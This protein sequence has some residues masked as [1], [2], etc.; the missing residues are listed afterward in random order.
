MQPRDADEPL[1]AEHMQQLAEANDRLGKLKPACV[2]AGFNGWTC[3][4]FAVLCVPFA[5]FSITAG[6]LTVGLGAVAWN[7]FRGR[8]L[9]KQFDLCGPRLL[10]WNQ[11]GFLALLIGY[12]SWQIFRSLTGPSPYESYVQ[13]NAELESMLGPIGE[14]HVI[15]SLAIYGGLIVGSIIFQG[16]NALYYFTRARHI[17]THLAQTA[18]WIVRV[19][20]HSTAA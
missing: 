5:L 17:R 20:R 9:L 2:L 14:L 8:K 11:I 10:G 7:E 3:A 13:A 12:A 16:L 6:V 19:Q 4:V 1:S 18:G 15:I